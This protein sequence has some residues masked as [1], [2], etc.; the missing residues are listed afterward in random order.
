MPIVPFFDKNTGAS[1]GPKPSG[2]GTSPI[3]LDV[4]TQVVQLAP[5]ATGSIT[6]NTPT[7]GVAPFTYSVIPTV[8]STNA[9]LT[10]SG[11]V[12][13]FSNPPALATGIANGGGHCLRVVVFDAQGNCGIGALVIYPNVSTVTFT[14]IEK[15][16][17]YAEDVNG[18]TFP[19]RTSSGVISIA[20]YRPSGDGFSYPRPLTDAQ[21]EGARLM[22]TPPGGVLVS[23]YERSYS[24][25]TEVVLLVLR[26]KMNLTSSSWLSSP[27]FLAWP[28]LAPLTI[29]T[30]LGTSA[31][32]T[33]RTESNSQNGKSYPSEYVG[34][35]VTAGTAPTSETCALSA[36][37]LTL[38]TQNTVASTRIISMSIRPASP[39]ITANSQREAT[40]NTAIA[41]MMRAKVR[42]TLTGDYSYAEL[43]W[44]FSQI[45][46]SPAPIGIRIRGPQAVSFTI[47]GSPAVQIS[48]NVAGTLRNL[49]WFRRG[50]FVGQYIG[51]D[52]FSLGGVGYFSVYPW[53]AAWTDFPEYPKDSFILPVDGG[54]GPVPNVVTASAIN[55]SLS[56]AAGAQ[57]VAATNNS[58]VHA[59]QNWGVVAT[60]A[61]GGTTS[62]GAKIEVERVEYFWKTMNLGAQK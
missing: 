50:T 49:G 57:P 24:A 37:T 59:S 19:A 32:Y 47:A 40:M 8:T 10:V 15:V 31:V 56:Y 58:V 28:D 61:Q 16:L 54:V 7:N 52:M 39:G 1:G 22:S 23:I 14:I 48:A 35:A 11:N 26:R 29:T 21:V 6:L 30:P 17:E 2:G 34:Y 5:T 62:G 45:G 46:T 43:R 44:G 3:W 4:P 41:G 13:E 53:D 38:E 36:G 55:T 12:L 9:T 51:I 33:G 25:S 42:V 27:D 18:Y 60:V 20:A